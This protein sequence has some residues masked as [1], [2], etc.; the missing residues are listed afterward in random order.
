MHSPV[1]EHA[2]VG[3]I[4]SITG[5]KLVISPVTG[6]FVPLP[7]EIFTS[8][9]EWVEVGTALAE[10]REGTSS[11]PVVSRFRGWVMRTLALPGQPVKRGEA[12]FWIQGS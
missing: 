5:H 10:V 9:G 12:L 8:E 11:V 1:L 4:P 6:R 2:P 7:A 3:D